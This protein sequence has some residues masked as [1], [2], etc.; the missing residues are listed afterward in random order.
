MTNLLGKTMQ[1]IHKNDIRFDISII[2]NTFMLKVCEILC[3]PTLLSTSFTTVLQC[4]HSL[5]KTYPHRIQPLHARLPIFFT[6]AYVEAIYRCITAVLKKM[7]YLQN[8]QIKEYECRGASQ[9]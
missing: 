8:S 6:S 1:F 5:F 4:G 9:G 3:I 2:I 7:K